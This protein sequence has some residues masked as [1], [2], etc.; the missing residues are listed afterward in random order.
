MPTALLKKQCKALKLA[1]IPNC[2]QDVKYQNAD[3]YLTEL[4]AEELKERQARKV[5]LL[6]RQAR[7]PG[8]KT[9]ADFD[10]TPV[11]LPS[12]TTISDLT[13]LKFL[14]RHE[15]ILALGAVGTGKT[16]LATALGLKACLSGKAVRF[17]RCLDLANELLDKYRT[18]DLP[19]FMKQMDKM[20]LLIIDELGF[21]PLCRDGA[22]L[23]F[24]VVADCYERRS[25]IITSNLK[26]GEWNSVLGD[27]RLTAALIDR[28]VHHAHVLAFSGESFRL[29]NA[30][31][32]I[33]EP[34]SDVA[35]KT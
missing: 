6:V 23:L 15:N 11:T 3:Q 31:S 18:G 28:L 2:Y 26:F 10:W 33:K 14:E 32:A 7:F 24:N 19:R 16:H 22:E 12:S 27:S 25:L 4:F 21:V 5:A 34:L 13:E 30:L 1:H 8:H 29:R 20:D 17:F 9:L 35:A